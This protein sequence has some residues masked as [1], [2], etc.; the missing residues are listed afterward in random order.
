ML[1]LRNLLQ[2]PG[3]VA[4]LRGF[5]T[6]GLTSSR[7]QHDLPIVSWG[8]KEVGSGSSGSRLGQQQKA[9]HKPY[10]PPHLRKKDSSCSKH[11]KK[12]DSQSSSDHESS[13][14]EFMS[15]DSDYSDSDTLGRESNATQSSKVRIAA[16]R[17]VQVI[18]QQDGFLLP[19][20]LDT[21][22]VMQGF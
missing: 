11:I 1:D 14:V 6:Y 8:E 19:T 4:A 12:L 18:L 22:C 21:R 7:L 15:S 5:F 20:L 3:F 2:V 13:T 9:D 17:C 10:R 16:I